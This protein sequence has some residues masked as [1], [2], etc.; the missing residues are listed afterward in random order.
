MSRISAELS[1]HCSSLM[2]RWPPPV[3]EI[4]LKRYGLLLLFSGKAARLSGSSTKEHQPTQRHCQEVYRGSYSLQ[5]DRTLWSQKKVSTVIWSHSPRLLSVRNA[6][7]NCI[8]TEHDNTRTLV[9]SDSSVLSS[10]QLTVCVKR[11]VSHLWRECMSWYTAL[12]PDGQ[13]VEE[14]L[15]WSYIFWLHCNV[16]ECSF[17][18]Y[19]VVT[20]IYFS[21]CGLS[22]GRSTW[23]TVL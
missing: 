6:K 9:H 12:T 5:M 11:C 13:Q 4:W 23:L 21:F 15:C 8:A 19:S 1:W 14:I 3:T 2:P 18:C 7:R 22:G 17:T 20:S 10:R 16:H